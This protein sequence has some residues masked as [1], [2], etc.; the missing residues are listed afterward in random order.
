MG[1]FGERALNGAARPADGFILFGGG[2]EHNV[3]TWNRLREQV[4]VHGRPVEEFGG[5]YVSL[6]QAG[7]VD[8]LRAE[9]EAWRDAGG[10]HLSVVTMGQGLDSAESHIDY[11]T[12]VATALSLH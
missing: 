5:D 4:T 12:S 11:I 9:A 1:G 10:T 2:I 7:E 3:G 6:P 8:A